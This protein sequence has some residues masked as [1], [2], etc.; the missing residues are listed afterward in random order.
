MRS[1]QF[2]LSVFAF[3]SG[4]LLS[5]CSS[6]PVTPE[7]TV[8]ENMVNY[9]AEA[10]DF[11]SSGGSK[12]LNFKTNVK[13]TIKVS[14]TQGSSP[15]CTVSQT[16]G[17]GGTFSLA[18]TVKENTSFEDRNVVLVLTA[19]N[20]VK[21]VI[22]N[23][24]Q[25]N[26]I[27][28][29]T[30]RFEV[31]VEGG[32]IDVE[33]KSNVDYSFEIA[34]DCQDWIKQAPQS[35]A[36]ATNHL[37]FNIAESKEYDKREGKIVFTSG[38]ITETV[39]VYQA[40]SSILVLS[41]NEYTLGS[42]G[43]TVSVDISSNFEFETDMPNVDWIKAAATTRAVSSH[44]LVY[45]VLKNDT[46]DDREAVIVFKDANSDKKES[47]TIKQR[48]KDAILLSTGKIEIGQSGG[49]FTVDVNSNIDYSIEI[50]SS[51]SGWISRAS[52]ASTRAL[53]KT[54]PSFN[55]SSS[56][57]YNK[58]E[59]EIYFKGSNIVDT[60]KVYQSGGAILVLSQDTYNLAGEA[61]TI[62]VQLKSN[63]SYSV[64]ISA[65]WITDASTRAVSS[66]VKSFNIAMNKTGASRTGK[67]TFKSSDGT[68]SATVTINQASIVEAKSLTI[69][70]TNTSG[71][72]GDGL[73]IGKPY[74]L[75]VTA[76]P[77]N[78]NTSYEWK[79]AD[80]SIATISG[81][82]KTVTLNT[83]DYGRSKVLV[84]D[85]NSGVSATYDFN[86]WVTDFQFTETSR[87][88]QY[89]YPTIKMAL[90]DTHQLKYSCNPSYATRVFSNLKAF[91][92]K[93]LYRG[94]YA[95]VS[96]S[97]IVDIDENGLMT[98]K[99][100]GTTII[101]A[102]NGN[103]VAKI[104]GAN[105]GIFVEVVKEITP[106][107][108][109]GGHGYV[110]L[111]LPSGKLWATQNFGAFDDTEYGS[112]YLW[113]DINKVQTS[114]GNKWSTPT[115]AEFNELINNCSHTW[116]TKSGVSGYLFTGKNGATLFLPAA[117][118]KNYIEGYGYSKAQ[119]EGKWL[120]YWTSSSQGDWEGQ[121]FAYMLSGTSSSL[122]T[123]STYNTTI[124]AA[125][126]RPISR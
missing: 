106:Y 118:Y 68:K 37:T 103:G 70:F 27:T 110:D 101:N 122:S 105:D 48:Q 23:Q 89:G 125:S 111:G 14:D 5:A 64:S 87:D 72:M 88:I 102:N 40:G 9:F 61:S 51:C 43:G 71:T 60:L 42:E 21:N 15:W 26:A 17:D 104:N 94:V 73:Y 66:S 10:M 13:W 75:S 108:T 56:E 120:M 97:T 99:K 82:G 35:R 69:N 109:I 115:R 19:G 67:I 116:T 114:W 107:G 95:I 1:R 65:A 81:S 84:T 29:T 79:V 126:I 76:T 119:S 58:R 47:V 78:A 93:E 11:P 20:I 123:N 50:P 34:K 39:T 63:I 74:K 124:V 100:I 98:A 31:G 57:E 54:T 4:I 8:P 38:D 113:S 96:K 117:G 36:M 77:S 22:V 91:N 41:Q 44:T 49:Q 62:S 7:V 30:D 18:V 25:K 90:G 16:E 86:T 55:V 52:G 6:D 46:Y 33:V 3:L 45:T 59:G 2:I 92:F 83:K 85:K 24:K 28:L 80:P 32:N 121:P 112:Y 12:I 53:T